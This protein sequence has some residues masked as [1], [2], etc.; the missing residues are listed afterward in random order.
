MP[1]KVINQM[2][3]RTEFVLRSM[4]Q[5]CDFCAVCWEFRISRKT[6][7]KWKERFLRDGMSGLSERSRRPESSPN[8]LD[9]DQVC[10]IVRLKQAHPHWGPRKLREVF[11]RQFS[12]ELVPSESSFKRVLDQAGLVE[13]RRHRKSQEAGTR[14]TQPIAAERPNHVWTVDFKGWWYTL[15][16]NRF[17]PLTIRD[18]YS[19][20]ILCARARAWA[21]TDVVREQFQRV[22]EQNGLPEIIRSDNGAPFAAESSPLGLTRLSA[23]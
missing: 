8:K 10:R 3:A 21:R 5:D 18:D 19:R 2:N 11:A 14:L 20:F 9:E 12:A 23:W 4:R 7:Y 16:R 17:E 13:H 22:F 15:D 1:W 6:E